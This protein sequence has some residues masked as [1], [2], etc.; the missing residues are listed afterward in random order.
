[1]H[2][3]IN[4]GFFMKVGSNVRI[5]PS[6][7]FFGNQDNIEIG[8]NVRI[9]AQCIISVADVPLRI[10]SNVHIACG[11]YLFAG[12]GLTISN[13]VGLSSRVAVYTAS[14]DYTG[15]AIVGPMVPMEFRDLEIGPIYL[16]AHVAVGA[17]SVIMPNVRMGLGSCAGALTLIR[18]NVESG[19]VVS[20]NPMKVVAK[21]NIVKLAS[22]E[23]EYRKKFP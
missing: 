20:G 10:G 21:R 16:D 12:H 19:H 14:D 23:Q 2:K 11:C 7:I 6:V 18:K 8:D 17:G 5:H 13:Y 22:L 15:G 1:M 9:D 3:Y 4:P